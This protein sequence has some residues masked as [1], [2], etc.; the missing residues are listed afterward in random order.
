[1]DQQGTAAETV[2][3]QLVSNPDYQVKIAE[4]RS[5]ILGQWTA[6]QESGELS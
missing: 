5:R 1:M 2:Q 4:L 3:E 6:A